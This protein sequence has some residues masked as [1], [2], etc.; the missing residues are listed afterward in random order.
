MEVLLRDQKWLNKLEGICRVVI[1][2]TQSFKNSEN[3]KNMLTC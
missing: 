2:V 3:Q 1:R